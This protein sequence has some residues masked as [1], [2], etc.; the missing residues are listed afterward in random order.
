M[1]A[2][3]IPES[4]LVVIHT[5]D[6][7]VLLLERTG[8][9]GFWQSVTGSKDHHDEPLLETARREV[10]E[11]TGIIVGTVDVPPHA[12][13]NWQHQVTYEIY[14]LWRHRYPAGVTHNTEHW[15][16][17]TV[18]TSTQVTLAPHEHTSYLWLPYQIAAQRC[19]SPSNRTA[20]LQLPNRLS[21]ASG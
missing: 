16:G 2:Q 10:A 17:L 5:A 21:L 6:L 7:Q 15:F 18:P 20:I 12:L 3:K 11:E 8:H 1:I 14:P 4:A 9:P 19:F 13:V